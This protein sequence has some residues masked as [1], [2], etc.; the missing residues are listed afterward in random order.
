M[1]LV[2]GGLAWLPAL[3]WRLD[4]HWKRLKAEVPHLKRA[5]S[6][7]IHEHFWLTTQPLDEPDNVADLAET[8]EMVGTDRIMFSTDYPHW[9]YDDPR[10]VFGRLRLSEEKK[11]RVFSGNAKELYGLA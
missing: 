7:T 9:D 6:E 11:R 3:K 2:E 1:V 4:K 8:F 10:F 5:P